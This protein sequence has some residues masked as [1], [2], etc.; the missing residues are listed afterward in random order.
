[1][2]LIVCRLIVAR[3]LAFR[4]VASGHPNDVC[5]AFGARL[6]ALRVQRGLSQEQ[7]SEASGLHRTYVSSVE[8]GARNISLA[9]MWRLA[10][11]LDT[12]PADFFSP[13]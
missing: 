4:D 3:F 7:L 12:T 1:M 9:A 13:H 8:R 10:V 11:A 2:L 6:R 5:A